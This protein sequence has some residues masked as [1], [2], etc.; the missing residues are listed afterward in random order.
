MAHFV[1]KDSMAQMSLAAH[2]SDIE[3][4]GWWFLQKFIKTF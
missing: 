3:T 1:L 4:A 2:V